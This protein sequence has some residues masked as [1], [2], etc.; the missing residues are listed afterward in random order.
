[1]AT[2]REEMSQIVVEARFEN[3]LSDN[4]TVNVLKYAQ[5]LSR[6]GQ[7]AS[8]ARPNRRSTSPTRLSLGQDISEALAES[9]K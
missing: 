3:N 8:R 4:V 2:F 7:R 1:M 5:D 9:M 6:T